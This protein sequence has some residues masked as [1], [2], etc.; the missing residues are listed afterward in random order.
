VCGKKLTIGVANRVEALTKGALLFA[1][2]VQRRKRTARA[3]AKK[4]TPAEEASTATPVPSGRT[5]VIAGPGSGK[6]RMLTHRLAHLIAERDVA[7]EAC[8]A[9]TFTRRATEELK[10]RLKALLPR[11]TCTVHSY[12]SLGLAI[13]RADGSAIGLTD[14]RIASEAE[15]KEALKETL[16]VTDSRADIAARWRF[17]HVLADEFQD[18]DDMQYRLLRLV[19]GDDLCVIG[20]PDQTIY[21][22]RGALETC[23]ARLARD[24]P[25]CRTLRLARNYR[26]SGAIVS[27]SSALVGRRAEGIVRPA[28]EPVDLHVAADEHL[29]A[30]FVAARIAELMGGH[31]MLTSGG[32]SALGFADFAVLYRTDAQSAALREALDA[33]GI[34]FKKST[35]MPLATHPG[36]VALLDRLTG[37]DFEAAAATARE[38]GA[39]PA[40]LAEAKSWLAALAADDETDLREKVAL[41]TEADFFDARA[42]RVSL[43][44]M[45]AAKGLE[46]PVVFVVGLEDAV[47]PFFFPDATVPDAEER[48]LFYVAMTRAKD[49]LILSR[50]QTRF[51]HGKRLSLPPSRFLQALP[52]RAAA[53]PRR[54]PKQYSLF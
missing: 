26:S 43:L 27:A 48:R 41:A 13:L 1:A 29:E 39:E 9:V 34:P 51:W 37:L 20:D 45:H 23:F 12:H 18:I 4:A 28:G 54:K 53:G 22:F 6:T 11:K 15:R 31:D 42:D 40:A 25:A 3:P 10:A 2:P 5:G 7:P 38:A 14:F 36:V 32:T 21:G 19:A 44:T 17:A 16:G 33:L 50:A 8:L 24:L 46:F 35:P 49:R 30:A 47:T 52:L